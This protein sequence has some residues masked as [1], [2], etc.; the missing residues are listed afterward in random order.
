V[1]TND[2]FSSVTDFPDPTAES[3][4]ASLIGIDEI[5][6]QVVA[7]ATL[8]LDPTT[9]E[10]W[11][12]KHHGE[13]LRAV[14]EVRQR[15][16]LLVFEGDVGTG[17]TELAET[18]SDAVARAMKV[19][20]TLFS[21]SLSSRGKGAVGEM[22][23]LLTRAFAEVSSTASKARDDKG[24]VRRGVVLL[25]DEADALAQSREL[26]QM[27]HEDRAGVNAL[28]RGIDQLRND[29]LPVL[30]LLCTNR[31]GALDPAVLRRAAG[32][33]QFT[34]PNE[35]Q[36]RQLFEKLLEG[37]NIPEEELVQLVSLTDATPSRLY[38]CSYSDLRQRFVPQAVLDAMSRDVPLT[39]ALLV[40]RAK[41]FEPTRPFG[42]PDD[43]G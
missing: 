12:V 7:E 25:V 30:T 34:R 9:L 1:T 15:T 37:V 24:Q 27:H 14:D 21:L 2:L 18:F 13:I 19:D 16:P 4:F 3:R 43:V 42:A 28:I 5:K 26:T 41:T 33:F 8:L 11:S 29:Q 32:V 39:G 20:I 17:K 23:S 40:E 31:I 10:K 36:R 6:S 38:G 22:T 35:V